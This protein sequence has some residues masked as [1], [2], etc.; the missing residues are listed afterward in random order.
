MVLIREKGF[1]TWENGEEFPVAA[2][3]MQKR[4]RSRFS[5]LNPNQRRGVGE[6]VI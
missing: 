1:F 2:L 4:S 5:A 3:R 6:G